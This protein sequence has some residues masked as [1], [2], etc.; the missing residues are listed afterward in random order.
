MKKGINI[1]FFERA[2]ATIIFNLCKV[3]KMN[4][5]LQELKVKIIETLQLIDIEPDDIDPDSQL[6]GGDLGIDSIDVLELVM[7]IEKDYRLKIDSKETGEKVF[8][9]LKSLADFIQNN[10]PE[11]AS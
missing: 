4:D 8:S 1:Q 2:D 9:T 6:V 7:M 11:L 3:T 10:R 5:L